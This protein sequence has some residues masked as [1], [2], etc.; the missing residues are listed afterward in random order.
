LTPFPTHQPHTHPHT[1]P[2]AERGDTNYFC[3]AIVASQMLGTVGVILSAFVIAL[4]AK[5]EELTQMESV[6]DFSV[7]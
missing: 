2:D 6:S 4:K 7:G 3:D 1:S 5:L